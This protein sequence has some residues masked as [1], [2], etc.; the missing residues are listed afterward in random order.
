VS[1]P[2]SPAS[3]HAESETFATNEVSMRAR[4]EECLAFTL[5]WE[6]GYVDHPRDPGGPT[7][8]GITIATLS[9][10]LGRRAT[11][12][13]VAMLTNSVAAAIYRKKYWATI[14]GD[15]LPVGVDLMAFDIAVNM[16][17]GCA[18]RW[19][20]ETALLKP[21]DRI[22]RFDT[23]RCRHWRALRIFPVFSRGWL[24]RERACLSAAQTALKSRMHPA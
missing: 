1:K 21:A 8:R 12:A 24:R 5:Q 22:L 9:H 18:L 2:S 11:R 14:D 7:N 6:G 15:N 10:E 13:D 3:R 20:A 4:F 19:I 16:G 23:L 17:P